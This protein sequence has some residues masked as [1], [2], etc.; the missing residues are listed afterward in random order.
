MIVKMVVSLLI[1]LCGHDV[2]SHN[3]RGVKV[4]NL[5]SY[6]T[7]GQITVFDFSFDQYVICVNDTCYDE[8]YQYID[9]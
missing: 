9:F 6:A 1:L 4:D 2:D 7:I 3:W 5:D 8:T